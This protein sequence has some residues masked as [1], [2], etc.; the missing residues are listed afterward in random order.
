[1]A[2]AATAMSKLIPSGERVIVIGEP[3]LAFY[4]HLANRPAFERTED[5]ALLES[6]KTSVYLVTGVYADRAP[7]LREG[8]KKL[9]D[10]MVLLAKL[11]MCPKDIRLLDDFAPSDARLY[12]RHPDNTYDLKLYLLLPKS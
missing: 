2:E 7:T 1:M 5:L 8:L 9:N 12:Y 11:S 6:I 4:L 3:S 10:R